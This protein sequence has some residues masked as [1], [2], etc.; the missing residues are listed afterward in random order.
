MAECCNEE[1]LNGRNPDEVT[2]RANEGIVKNAGDKG[3][4]GRIYMLSYMIFPER[5]M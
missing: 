2:L 5:W 3:K 1:I 4:T